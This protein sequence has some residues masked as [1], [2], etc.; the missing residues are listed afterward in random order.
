M[1]VLPCQYGSIVSTVKHR[2]PNAQFEVRVLV[3]PPITAPEWGIPFGRTRH[4][5]YMHNQIEKALNQI[6]LETL[7]FLP[8]D[9]DP[10]RAED[11]I[12]HGEYG[13]AFEIICERLNENNVPLTKAQFESIKE[14]GSRMEIEEKYIDMIKGLVKYG[15]HE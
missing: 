6:I 14:I 3:G 5:K 11:M 4:I 12:S 1:E 13:L 2:T 15:L 8:E 9:T 10:L 7:S